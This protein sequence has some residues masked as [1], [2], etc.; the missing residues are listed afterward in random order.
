MKDA[1]WLSMATFIF[2]AIGGV[3]YG[4]DLGIISGALL[5]IRKSI[6]MTDNQMSFLVA[7]VLGGGSVATLVTGPLSDWFG[8]RRM[9]LLSSVIFIISVFIIVFAHTYGVLLFGR[10]VQGVGVGVITIAVP[11]YLTEVMPSKWRG[12][13]VT[14][15][16][17]LLTVGILLA[18]LVG[19]LF[20]DLGGNWRAMFLTAGIP[21]VVMF[22][23]CFFLTDSPRWLAMKGRYNAALAVLKKTRPAAEAQRELAQMKKALLSGKKG[24]HG[25]GTI[26]Q[27]RYLVPLAIVFAV[28][29][30]NQLTGINSF[31][32]FS[33]IIFKTAGLSSNMVA[34]LG[35]SAISGLNFVM[36]IIAL[37]LVD[38][39]ERRTLVAIG[40]AGIVVALVSSG[41][42]Y[43]WLPDGY[44]KGWLL[45]IGILVFI[46]FYALGPGAL[47]WTILS[48]L[49]PSRVRSSG[50]AIALFLNSMASTVLAS[51]FL[52]LVDTIHY[53]GVFWLCG[54][55]T[56]LY[57][58]LAVFAI[59]KTSGQS[60][61]DIEE[62]FAK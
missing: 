9:I 23:G 2:A 19:A 40:T 8:R 33:A 27:K 13:G 29:I 62:H 5:F 59:P 37:L 39:V 54:G 52:A 47:V 36:T 15:F 46:F 28:G 49:L 18:T 7:A 35:S 45:L 58:L 20:T 32:Q 38:K 56:V 44:T 60:L 55:F 10:L 51:L 57:C 6:P 3:L 11:L 61:E 41:A 53:Q 17:L 1:K 14:A 34:I 50:L 22:F 25:Q 26:W 21:G 12:R 24:L 30:L 16:Q 48:E 42:M 31:L 4:Y 43:A